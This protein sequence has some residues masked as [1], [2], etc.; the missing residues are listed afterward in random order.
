MKDAL[1]VLD[2]ESLALQG[3]ALALSPPF[4]VH[5][6]A[7]LGQAEGFLDQ[8]RLP[9]AIIDLHMPEHDG[10]EVLAR[11]KTKFPDLEIVFCSAEN[12]VERAI[13]CVRQGASDY[14]L[15]PFRK[16]DLLRVVSR[17]L[18]R[19]RL[20]TKAARL[21][22][23]LCPN[24]VEF[25]GHSRPMRELRERVHTLRHQTHLNVMILGE[26]GTGKE[27]IARLLHQ[28]E[29]AGRAFVVVNM[30][31]IPVTLIEADLFGVE[32]GAYTDA[33][34]SKPG[35][36]ELADSGDIFLDEIGD[37]PSDT[38]AKLLRV[39][40]EK[41]VER[42]GSHRS[43]RISFR[44]IS[45]TNRPIADLILGGA[46]RE[47]LVYRLSDMVLWVP[48]LREHKEDIAELANHFIART[49]PNR[50]AVL[51][52]GALETLKQYDWPGNIRQ[53]ESTLKRALVFNLGEVIDRVEIFDPTMMNPTSQKSGVSTQ[54]LDARLLAYERRLITESLQ[55]H[56]G[57]YLTAMKELGLPRS[58]FYRKLGQMGLCADESKG[59]S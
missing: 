23:F 41:Q 9:L 28:Q 31:A 5:C 30:A 14:V 44:A 50:P 37:L 22:R 59:V 58:T 2:D 48:P 3:F 6:F 1:L 34:V 54:T 27:V 25:V 32:K 10:L 47:D 33:K 42:V 26:S 7:K 57:D 17:A 35:K 21:D 15:K 45:A 18:E 49:R 55:R 56:S 51:S 8:H 38:Q 53:L 20:K 39:L 43:Q 16:E 52:D 40:Q 24:P 19:Q 11:W 29:P 46:F 36:F 4:E 12:R 13:E